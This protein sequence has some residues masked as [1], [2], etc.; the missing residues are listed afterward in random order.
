MAGAG[1]SG[2]GGSQPGRRRRRNWTGCGETFGSARSSPRAVRRSGTA[3]PGWLAGLPARGLRGPTLDNY[4]RVLDY[5]LDAPL[6]GRRLDSITPDDLDTRCS[7]YYWPTGAG[8]SHTGPCRRAP[9]DWWPPCSAGPSTTPSA[10]ASCEANPV[11]LAH[12]PSSKAAAA[13]E[14]PIW[15][16]ARRRVGFL[17]TAADDPLLPLWRTLAT[18]GLRRG[19]ALGLTWSALDLD[20]GVLHIRQ[21]LTIR[22]EPGKSEAA[23]TDRAEDRKGAAPGRPG[24]RHRH[25][26]SGP[27]DAAAPSAARRRPGAGGTA[28]ATSCSSGRPVSRCILSGSVTGSQRLAKA[29]GLPV[30]TLHGLRH[31]HCTALLLAGMS[32][33]LVSRRL[34]HS[35]PAFTLSRYG[36]VVPDEGRAAAQAAAAM[37]DGACDRARL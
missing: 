29:A 22:R 21:Q 20:G 28:N 11:K 30:L 36:H 5:V 2:D 15:T 31:S 35:S 4:S 9:F 16:P 32:P 25:C 34:G 3:S 8:R 33:V 1:R 7:R 18:C 13:E 24:R 27:P 37:V 19:E 12:P 14:R 10:A 26:P 6:A 23:G 17:T